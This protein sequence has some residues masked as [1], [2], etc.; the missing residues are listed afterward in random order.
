MKLH[1][2]P[3]PAFARHHVFGPQSSSLSGLFVCTDVHGA[4]D[5]I[6]SRG[7]VRGVL[8][9][10]QKFLKVGCPNCESILGLANS[11]DAIADCT[12]QV[13]D[14]L[15]T[16]GDPQASWVAKWQ[17]ISNYVAGVYAVKVVGTLPDEIIQILEDNGVRYMPRDGSAGDEEG[18]VAE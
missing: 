7:C 13:F 17:R 12:S 18:G 9:F 2:T 5:L 11:P 14:S 16:M 8:N 15:I 6:I 10:H 3:G 4:L 1:R